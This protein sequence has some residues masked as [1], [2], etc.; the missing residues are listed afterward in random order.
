MTG[1]RRPDGD[2]GPIPTPARIVVGGE[3]LV[4]RIR[5]VD[6]TIRDVSGGG[7]FNAARA[8]ARLGV[9]VAFLG[10]ISTDELGERLLGD[11]VAD[12]VATHLVTR[13]DAAT[14]MAHATL[15]PDGTASYRFEIAGTAAP[16]L[17]RDAAL[18]ALAWRP[19]A[20]HVG[21]LGL[22]FQPIADS[23]E[24]VV[25]ALPGDVLLML[26][27]NARPSTIPDLPTWRARIRRLARRAD[28]IRASV[29][30]LRVLEDGTDPVTAARALAGSH[31]LVLLTDGA[32]PVR[33][34]SAAFPIVELPLHP[35]PVVDTVGAGD[36]F[37]GAFLAWWLDQGLDRVQLRDAGLATVAARVALAAA[38]ITCARVGADPPT[39]ADLGEA[40]SRR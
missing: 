29:D 4:D 25:D 40:W 39:R 22:V 17:D 10:C 34:V 24:T 28:I 2:L 15:D 21:T 16:A 14:T 31:A 11:L 23:L 26:D 6:G 36:S 35:G 38:A 20:L 27:P 5:S 9:P 30:D 7:Q 12:G 18:R 19:S 8:I 33:L 3:C 1:P 13:T 37:G 32:R